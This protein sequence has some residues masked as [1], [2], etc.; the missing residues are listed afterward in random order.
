MSSY[1]NG[2]EYDMPKRGDG[3]RLETDRILILNIT[4]KSAQNVKREMIMDGIDK[5]TISITKNGD[6]WDRV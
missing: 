2:Y 3:H 1:S 4:K 5:D 6:W